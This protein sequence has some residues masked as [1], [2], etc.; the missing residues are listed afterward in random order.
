MDPFT[1]TAA[2]EQVI[3]APLTESLFI[4]GPPGCGKTSA[5]VGRLRRII[6]Q[7]IPAESVLILT[8]QRSLAAPYAQE[9]SRP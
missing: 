4:S 7:G 8:P 1:Y 9:I 3:A 6:G 5:A 2:Q